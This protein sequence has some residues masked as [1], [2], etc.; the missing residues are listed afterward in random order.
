M[1]ESNVRIL[2]FTQGAKI[3]LALE[4]NWTVVCCLSP[5]PTHKPHGGM[6]FVTP[7][8]NP[9]R[10]VLV[11]KLRPRDTEAKGPDQGH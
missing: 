3:T 8:S 9:A 6:V 5:P 4:W 11:R 1:R 7:A 10:R 2:A